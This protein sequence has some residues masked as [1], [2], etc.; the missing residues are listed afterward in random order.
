MTQ[1]PTNVALWSAVGAPIDA[2]GL[3]ALLA[4]RY[5]V[6]VHTPANPG[7]EIRGQVTAESIEV[8]FTSMT[9]GQQVPA[10]ASAASAVVASTVDHE[11]GDLTVHLRATGADTAAGGSRMP[12]GG[13]FLDQATVDMIR[14]WIT[15]GALDN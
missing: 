7:G 4:G 11:T 12:R 3:A 1:D 14:Q 6:N 5:Y 2:A 13:L 8:L 9:G 15:D 10:N